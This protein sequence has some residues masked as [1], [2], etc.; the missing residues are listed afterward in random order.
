[1]WE[2]PNATYINA[3]MLQVCENLKHLYARYAKNNSWMGN[4]CS[5]GLENLKLRKPK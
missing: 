5:G 3:R 4:F 1:M 2:V